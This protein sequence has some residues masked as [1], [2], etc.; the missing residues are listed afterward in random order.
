MP[1]SWTRSYCLSCVRMWVWYCGSSRGPAVV[2][3]S[4]LKVQFLINPVFICEKLK[5]KVTLNEDKFSPLPFFHVQL[6]ARLSSG[7]VFCFVLR[8]VQLGVTPASL[9]P[10]GRG[11]ATSAGL[12][13][14]AG[15][16]SFRVRKHLWRPTGCSFWISVR[17]E[18]QW[19][20]WIS[21]RRC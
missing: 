9:A 7:G 8:L 5:D 16:Y 6:I 1:H 12:I 14:R 2:S 20:H 18:K 13:W 15:A 3:N 4:Y 10:V 19:K 11:P 17:I 21:I